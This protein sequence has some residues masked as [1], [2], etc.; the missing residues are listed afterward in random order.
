MSKTTCEAM[1]TKIKQI[2]QF[3]AFRI[4]HRTPC[5]RVRENTTTVHRALEKLESFDLVTQEQDRLPPT[6]ILTNSG[7]TKSQ[8]K[9]G[10]GQELTGMLWWQIPRTTKIL[11]LGN[12]LDREQD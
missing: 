4:F 10:G 3:T 12:E 2:R 7:T 1:A 8:Q 6:S 5:E 11:T 9:I